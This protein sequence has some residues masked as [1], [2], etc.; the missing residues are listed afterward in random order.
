[1]AACLIEMSMLGLWPAAYL[2][3]SQ[4]STSRLGQMFL[5]RYPVIGGLLPILKSTVDAVFPGALWTWD[6]LVSFIFSC[7]LAAFVAYAIAAWR[8]QAGSAVRLRWIIIPLIA[9]ELTL[10]LIPASFTTDI[11]NYAIYGEMPVLYHVNPFIHTPGEFPQS[12]LYYMIP[13]YWHDAPSVYGP[14]WIDFSVGVASALH[15]FGLADELVTYRIAANLAHLLN[16]AFV[17]RIARRL[18]PAAAPSAAIAYG[19]NPLLLVDFSMNGHNDVV[20]L[21]LLLGS[22]LL[23]LSGRWGWAAL[24]FGLSVAM[25]YTSALVALPLFVWAARARAA[26]WPGQLRALAISGLISV[27]IVIALYLPWVQGPDTFGPVW[28]WMS[29]PRINNFLPEP[30]LISIASWSSGLFGW[31]FNATWDAVFEGFKKLAKGALITLVLYE[32]WRARTFEDVLRGCAHVFLLFLLIVNTWI[33]PW[34]FTWPLAIAAPLGWNRLLVRVC[35]GMT[36]TA[37]LLP[38]ERQL[39]YTFVS[40]WGGYTLIAP[41]LLAALPPLGRFVRCHWPGW[42]LAEARLLERRTAFK[43]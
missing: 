1:M 7:V 25:K 22:C 42:F 30:T 33:M 11:F 27:A 23:L 39:G 36:L 38:Y 6:H 20:M 13:L 37:L 35:A 21:T 41:L 4:D 10:F 16:T 26:S 8:L 3:D 2:S 32:T 9:F 40:E 15:P 28:Y 18:N 5:G 24:V 17:W 12:P 43:G 34:Y 29:G 19:W 31:D 14:L